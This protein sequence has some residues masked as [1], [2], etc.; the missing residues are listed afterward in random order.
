LIALAGEQIVTERKFAKAVLA[1]FDV[2]QTIEYRTAT[3]AREHLAAEGLYNGGDTVEQD[4]RV[5]IAWLKAFG[6][7]AI[8]ISGPKSQEAW[9]AFAHPTESFA[10]VVPESALVRHAPRSRTDTGEAETY[11]AAL[12]NELLPAVEFRWEGK[13]RIH[14][15]TRAWPGQAVSIQ[16]THHPGWHAKA[17]G[18]VRQIKADGLGLMWLQPE[19][20]GPCD[21]QLEYDGG[22][23]LRIC[24]VLSASALVA[25]AIFFGWGVFRRMI[26]R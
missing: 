19:C 4:A 23:E 9:K 6:T 7:G 12:D 22:A 17:N 20:S 8:A 5:S 26:Y 24:H 10:H 15:R 21:V 16:V 13:N 3:W 25:L 18:A 14:I 2:T 1:P 11:V